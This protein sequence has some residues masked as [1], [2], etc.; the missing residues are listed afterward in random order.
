MKKSI[1]LPITLSLFLTGC[2]HTTAPEV[3]TRYAVTDCRYYINGTVITPDGNIWGYET[4]A[5][6]D[7]A[8][9]DNMPVWAGFDDNG[10]PDDI[11]DDEIIGLV[12][13]RNTAIYDALENELSDSFELERTGNTI[14]IHSF[15]EE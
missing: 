13:D 14:R 12:Y 5:V 2:S 15:K 6:S 4:G 1:I 7:T 10:T 9:Y 8:V 11:Y 3:H